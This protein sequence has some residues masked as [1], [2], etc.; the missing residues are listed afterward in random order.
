L[1]A[2]VRKQ[3]LSKKIGDS[4]HAERS[5]YFGQAEELIERDMR[6]A[7]EA[8]GQNLRDS[9]PEADVF[10]DGTSNEALAES[11]KRFIE[12]IFGHPFRTP[13]REE[14]GMFHAYGAKLRSAQAGRQV[15]A[16]IAR[17]GELVC[18]GTNEVA[19]AFGG[20]YWAGDRP[21]G[22][23]HERADDS[24]Q[25]MTRSLFAD[26]LARLRSKGW[27]ASSKADLSLEGCDAAN[28]DEVLKKMKIEGTRL[29]R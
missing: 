27:L 16:A 22:R 13:T 17:D 1:S 4:H 8:F 28:V 20:Q 19:K 21:D 23:D 29:L 25:A 5:H 9:F 26:L 14:V 12:I 2:R 10:L 24:T 3:N 7:G 15:G 18:I 6:E 11:A